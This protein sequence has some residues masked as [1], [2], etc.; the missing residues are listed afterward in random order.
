[1][2]MVVSLLVV[3]VVTMPLAYWLKKTPE[4]VNYQV[5]RE[6]ERQGRVE[7]IV[8]TIIPYSPT[9]RLRDMPEHRIKPPS[10]Y[11]WLGTETD[12]ADLLSRM[13]HASRIAL[14]IGLI[15]TTISV[16]IGI[17]IGGLMGYFVGKVDLIC[18]R[19]IEVFEAIPT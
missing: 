19:L 11:H 9:D 3:I 8:R 4:T 6:M 13:I 5:Y 16:C 12:G 18:M 17:F 15:S 10:R 7:R 14:S 2:R 1:A